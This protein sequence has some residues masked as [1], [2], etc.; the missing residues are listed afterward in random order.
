MRWWWFSA[1]LVAGQSFALSSAA[2]SALEFPDNGTA[3]FSRGG[4]WVATATDPIAAHYN[5]GA[6]ATQPTSFSLGANFVLQK[7]CFDRRG[8]DGEVTGPT[9]LQ[10]PETC[11]ENAGKVNAIPSAGFV[12]RASKELA[13]G[14]AVVP[15]SSFG[16]VSWPDAVRDREERVQSP[17]PAPQRYL[18]LLTEGTI[19][20]PTLS[21]GYSI[22]DQLHVGAG[23]I[24]GI[25]ILEFQSMSMSNVQGL[26]T[27]DYNQ[28][29]RSRIKARD[30]FVP[31]FVVGGLYQPTKNLDIGVWYRFVDK[32][33]AK[34]DLEIVA[35][36][37]AA[38]G[39]VRDQCPKAGVEPGPG[40]T[41]AAITQAD[42]AAR[43]TLTIPMEA[44]AGVRWHMPQKPA[45]GLL[46]ERLRKDPYPTRDPLRDDLYDLELDLTWA[47]N[48]AADEVQIRFD[49]GINVLGLP[50]TVPTNA[51]RPTGWKDSFGARLGGQYA[52]I[53]N[54]LGM[55]AGTWIETSAVDDEYLT[56]TGVPALRGGVG[57]G[58]VVRALAVDVEAGY[59]HIWNGGLDNGGDGKLKA[60]AGSGSPDNRSNHA[61][62]GGSVTQHANVFSV[63]IVA[64]L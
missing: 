17:I 34:G 45:T 59:Q 23:F 7:I 55:R 63:G 56:V 42:D 8:T 28:D 50:G 38:D 14:L 25:A 58:F 35:P 16:K 46:A 27:D 61:V 11:N 19:L 37:Y 33:R 29:T 36:Y 54:L 62:N 21:A 26:T 15:P 24:A 18:S 9:P 57:G 4:A 22:T 39:Q 51:D 6:I 53:R 43:V 10:Y 44:R 30:L 1:A 2:S 3:Q 5:P 48:S 32:I 52:L 20:Y 12:W 13:L 60:I 40:E 47:N 31:G 64:R 41:C 49:S